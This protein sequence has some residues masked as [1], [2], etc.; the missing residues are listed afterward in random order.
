MDFRRRTHSNNTPHIR[1]LPP[2]PSTPLRPQVTK[3]G[4]IVIDTT[5]SATKITRAIVSPGPPA[6]HAPRFKATRCRSL[7]LAAREEQADDCQ[8]DEDDEGGAATNAGIPTSSQY[9]TRPLPFQGSAP[10]GC[11]EFLFQIVCGLFEVSEPG[12]NA[13]SVAFTSVA[14]RERSGGP[15]P[16][17]SAT[18]HS[19]LLIECVTCCRRSCSFVRMAGGCL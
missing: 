1:Y 19:M 5:N 3:I 12:V 9:W 8:H 4:C 11:R 7:A 13:E 16:R 18:A 6:Q 17:W 15:S 2:A 14:D 10:C